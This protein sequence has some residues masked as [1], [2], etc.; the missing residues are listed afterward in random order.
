[1]TPKKT[2]EVLEDMEDMF[3]GE[4]LPEISEAGIFEGQ[5]HEEKYTEGN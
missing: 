5:D 1:M 4:A 2:K 3:D